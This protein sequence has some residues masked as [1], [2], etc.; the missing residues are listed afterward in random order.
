MPTTFAKTAIGATA[1]QITTND[2][3][4]FGDPA[5]EIHSIAANTTN[6]IYVGLVGVLTSTGFQLAAGQSIAL[7]MTFAD[8]EWT[9]SLAVNS[10]RLHV[11]SES[12]KLEEIL[13]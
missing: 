13:L 3:P 11:E 10:R 4:L 9:G 1:L 5:I 2:V 6:F 7:P 8:N 12:I